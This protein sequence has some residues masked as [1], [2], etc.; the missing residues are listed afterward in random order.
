MNG[1]EECSFGLALKTCGDCHLPGAN[2]GTHILVYMTV[3]LHLQSGFSLTGRMVRLSKG[4]PPKKEM[5][6][7]I[8]HISPTLIYHRFVSTQ[9]MT[10]IKVLIVSS[11]KIGWS[12]APSQLVA[13]WCMA[14]PGCW[15]P[16]CEATVPWWMNCITSILGVSCTNQLG[17]DIEPPNPKLPQCPCQHWQC[18]CTSPIYHALAD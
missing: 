4:L 2:R 10:S 7:R 3:Q 6:Q 18:V 11:S 12:E 9:G 13:L 17:P 1:I 5:G 14:V 8:S 16:T 15:T